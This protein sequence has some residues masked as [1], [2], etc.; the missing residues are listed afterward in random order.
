MEHIN[1]GAFAA[2]QLS[3][4]PLNFHLPSLLL[5]VPKQGPRVLALCAAGILPADSVHTLS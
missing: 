1:E 3:F 2:L 4:F 5:H